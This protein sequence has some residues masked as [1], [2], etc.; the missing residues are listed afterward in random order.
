MG[1]KEDIDNEAHFSVPLEISVT[2]ERAAIA[3]IAAELA[4]AGSS[5][6]G[7][8]LEDDRN[9][10]ERLHLTIQVRSRLHLMHIMRGLRHLSTVTAVARRLDGDKRIMLPSGD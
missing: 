8:N 3:A 7:V 2:D 10:S 9:A 4:K 5:I 1:W 6:V